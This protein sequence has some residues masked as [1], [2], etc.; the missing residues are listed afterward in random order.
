MRI[1]LIDVGQGAATL[2]EFSCGVVLVDTGGERNAAFDSEAR[3]VR[4]LDQF[5]RTRKH[6]K[7]TIALL[8]LTHPHV[9]HTRSAMAVFSR[10]HVQN[11]VTDGM[12]EGS[13]GEQQSDLLGAAAR[14]GIGDERVRAVDIPPAGLHDRIIDPISCPDG[15]PDIRVFWGA[16]AAH[17]V[18][19]DGE[20]LANANNRSEEHTSELQSHA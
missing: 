14:A 10:Y 19:W 7:S 8:V 9:D 5:F 1:H 20:S 3:L 16:V 11:V 17:D 18:A 4:Y 15:D 2:V 13:G 12:T 6:L